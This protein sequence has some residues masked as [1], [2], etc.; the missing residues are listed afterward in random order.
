MGTAIMVRPA[1]IDVW[2]SLGW[3]M[4]Q[5]VF[6]ELVEAAMAEDPVPDAVL[7]VKLQFALEGQ[8][9]KE[10]SAVEPIVRDMRRLRKAVWRETRFHLRTC[11]GCEECNP[12]R[13][14]V[15]DGEL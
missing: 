2:Q 14:V 5:I 15:V 6:A 13:E 11:P 8:L 10:L 7:Q 3:S 4:D 1:P 9:P 12:H